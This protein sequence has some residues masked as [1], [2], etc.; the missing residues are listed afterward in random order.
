MSTPS[1]GG[2]GG[3]ALVVVLV[4]VTL[5]LT[6]ALTCSQAQQPD[7]NEGDAARFVHHA[8]ERARGGEQHAREGVP[9][10]HAR[11]LGTVRGW[12]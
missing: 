10:L 2:G 4:V 5:T 12:G 7:H 3:G 9:Q 6:L 8:D 11:R 1:G